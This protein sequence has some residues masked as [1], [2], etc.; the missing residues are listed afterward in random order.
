MLTTSLLKKFAAGIDDPATT[1]LSAFSLVPL[2]FKLP[3]PVISTLLKFTP[4]AIVANPA[5]AVLGVN[6]DVEIV[7]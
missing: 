3:A 7:Q 4:G 5:I 1:K 2:Y 6:D